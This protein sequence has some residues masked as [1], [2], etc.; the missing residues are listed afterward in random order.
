MRRNHPQKRLLPSNPVKN[1]LFDKLMQ[2]VTEIEL[3]RYREIHEFNTA[4]R[5]PYDF[6]QGQSFSFLLFFFFLSFSVF[7]SLF[8]REGLVVRS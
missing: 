2:D 7:C 3:I 1:K 6:R 4:L 5:Y 8:L